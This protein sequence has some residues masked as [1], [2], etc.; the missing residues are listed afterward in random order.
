[1]SSPW[2]FINGTHWP[3]LLIKTNAS[4]LFELF[5]IK[6][7]SL[8]SSRHRYSTCYSILYR[9]QSLVPIAQFWVYARSAPIVLIWDPPLEWGMSYT[10]I[11]VHTHTLSET[12][13]MILELHKKDQL[14]RDLDRESGLTLASSPEF[15]FAPN[16]CATNHTARKCWKNI[17]SISKIIFFLLLG[18]KYLCERFVWNTSDILEC[19]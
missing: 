14:S 8:F 1:M 2:N 15:S 11:P 13:L 12:P 16:Q 3:S 5:L 19:F 7:K 18:D 9:V 4:I 6:S 17:L 10:F